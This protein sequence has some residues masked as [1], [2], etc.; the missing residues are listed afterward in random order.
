MKKRNKKKGQ[1]TLEMALLI[2]V[3][4]GMT[5]I[6]RTWADDIKIF[7]EFLEEPWKQVKVMMESGVWRNDVAEGR[8]LHPARRERLFCVKGNRP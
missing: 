7:V 6:V 3:M 1:V 4:I 5:Q 8:F 2:L